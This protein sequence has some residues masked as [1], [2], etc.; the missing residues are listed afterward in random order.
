MKAFTLALESLGKAPFSIGKRPPTRE[1]VNQYFNDS[2]GVSQYGERDV[3]GPWNQEDD[4]EFVE[5]PA[6][7]QFKFAQ[8]GTREPNGNFASAAAGHERTPNK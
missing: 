5:A 7:Q 1:L 4:W 8:A 6:F 3:R 2:T